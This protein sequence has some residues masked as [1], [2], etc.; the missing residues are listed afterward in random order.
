MRKQS[1]FNNNHVN[2]YHVRQICHCF[3][4][5][6]LKNALMCSA[7]SW[8][9]HPQHQYSMEIWLRWS[10]THHNPKFSN[11]DL[12]LLGPSSFTWSMHVVK[13][14]SIKTIPDI[15]VS[16]V[17]WINHSGKPF[18][19]NGAWWLQML[20]S[21][22]RKRKSWASL[23]WCISAISNVPLPTG[24]RMNGW[25][26]PPKLSFLRCDLSSNEVTYKSVTIGRQ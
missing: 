17:S 21:K 23:T 26:N 6:P 24:I 2:H 18:V 3:K 16:R 7:A 19:L 10:P 12:R 11:L 1:N 20:S 14:I 8:E 13:V 15:P 22:D 4:A 5:K 9:I 25:I